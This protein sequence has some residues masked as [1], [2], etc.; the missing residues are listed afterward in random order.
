[1]RERRRRKGRREGGEG[2]VRRG[3]EQGVAL[4]EA[5][6]LLSW[7]CPCCGPHQAPVRPAQRPLHA[8]APREGEESLPYRTSLTAQ[9]QESLTQK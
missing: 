3:G 7:T 6:W 5:Q 8:E 4:A 2:G 9:G 1:M